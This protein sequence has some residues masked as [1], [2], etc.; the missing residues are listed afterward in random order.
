MRMFLL[1]AIFACRL[2]FSAGHSQQA[3]QQGGQTQRTPL[4]END[5]VKV[6]K[7]VI[8]PRRAAGDAPARTS[9]RNRGDD[10]RDDE[11]R[12]T[13]RADGVTRVGDRQSLLAARKSAEHDARGRERGR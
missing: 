2:F 5:D 12:R 9:T 10:G 6:W 1:G 3:S 4:L 8:T 11:D 13:E 7:S